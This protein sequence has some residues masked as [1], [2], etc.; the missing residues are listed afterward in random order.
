MYWLLIFQRL[1]LIFGHV[2][3]LILANMVVSLNIFTYVPMSL[4]I[5][6]WYA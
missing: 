2:S 1:D 3:W 4:V 5:W 6:S